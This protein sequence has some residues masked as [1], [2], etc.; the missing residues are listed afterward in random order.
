MLSRLLRG[1]FFSVIPFYKYSKVPLLEQILNL[2]SEGETIFGI[3]PVVMVTM[4]I[5][6]SVSFVGWYSKLSRTFQEVVI[7]HVKKDLFNRS[8]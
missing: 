5:L 2:I 6:I 1:S 8:V 3:M 7:L 4:A